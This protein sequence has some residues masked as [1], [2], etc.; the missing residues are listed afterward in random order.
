MLG[1][2]P[3]SVC[4]PPGCLSMANKNN[5]FDMVADFGREIICLH[6][7]SLSPWMSSTTYLAPRKTRICFIRLAAGKG[8][9]IIYPYMRM[10]RSCLHLRLGQ[11]CSPST[12][13]FNSSTRLRTCKL[14]WPRVP[15]LQF[16]AT[17][18]KFSSSPTA[19]TANSARHRLPTLQC[20]CFPL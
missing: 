16:G 7:C 20:R 15:S 13:F 18:N 14:I 4:R 6:C 17:I 12:K 10:M 1:C 11:T 8:Y 3:C 2:V 19:Y 9:H 5:R